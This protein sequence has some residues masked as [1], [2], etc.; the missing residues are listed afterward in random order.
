MGKIDYELYQVKHGEEH[1]DLMFTNMKLIDK[2]KLNIEQ[3]HYDK[4]YSGSEDN[5]SSVNEVLE[6]LFVKF[7]LHFPSDYRARS[8]SVSDIVVLN[9]HGKKQA[10]F[11]D[12]FGFVEVPQFLQSN[13]RVTDLTDGLAVDGHIGTWHTVESMHLGETQLFLMEHDEYGDETACVIVD[14]SGK[15]LAEDVW[16]GFDQ[17]VLDM[18]IEEQGIVL[19][20]AASTQENN[21]TVML[22][23][24]GSQLLQT[25][26]E[27][28]N[29]LAAAEGYSE[30]NYNMIDGR[31]D[32]QSKL[33][34]EDDTETQ[35]EVK[36][37]KRP[38][39]L[40]K[41]KEK[42]AS[43]TESNKTDPPVKKSK[44]NISLD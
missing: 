22:A 5:K 15:L 13:V 33:T 31:I 2:L 14:S 1:R 10:Y 40:A 20:Q 38:S 28:D 17:E 44:D 36:N 32:V 42:Q 4:V 19:S 43:V 21:T 34:P 18:I 24:V 29:Y 12:S 35:P 30:E 41:L 39:V 6:S 27:P 37:E 16:N 23:D 9:D 25:G 7:N 8:M 26:N 11:C 3:S